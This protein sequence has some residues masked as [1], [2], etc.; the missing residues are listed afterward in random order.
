MNKVKI[1][2]IGSSSTGKSTVLEELRKELTAQNGYPIYQFFNESTRSIAKYGFPINKH[3]TDL[4]QLAISN[5]HL[6]HLLHATENAIYDRC[7]LDL[8]AYTRHLPDVSEV[9]LK[10]IEDT[11]A[12]ILPMYTHY[13]Y[14]PIT[15]QSVEDGVRSTDEEWRLKVDEEFRSILAGLPNVTVMPERLEDRVA[16]VSRLV[17]FFT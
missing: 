1:A 6:E 3:G 14:F 16:V 15:F 12:R 11:W 9:V 8:V 5:F 13:F 4:T 17:R 7:Y 10:Y 2:L